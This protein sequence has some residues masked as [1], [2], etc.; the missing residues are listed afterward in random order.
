MFGSSGEN[1][2]IC[3]PERVG[4]L[5]NRQDCQAG[6]SSQQHDGECCAGLARHDKKARM[7]FSA[8]DG[9]DALRAGVAA[10]NGGITAV[11]QRVEIGY[12]F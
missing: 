9:H 2:F 7:S 4:V 3:G 5:V 1:D 8:G 10:A 6:R 12:I 11:M